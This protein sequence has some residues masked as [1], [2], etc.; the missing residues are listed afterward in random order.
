MKANGIGDQDS[1]EQMNEDVLADYEAALHLGC[2]REDAVQKL[3]P[4]CLSST[5]SFLHSLFFSFFFLFFP[6]MFGSH[7]LFCN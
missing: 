2:D 1:A 5:L 7:A 6:V 4:R 3:G